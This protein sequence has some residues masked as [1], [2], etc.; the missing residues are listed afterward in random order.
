MSSRS[1]LALVISAWVAQVLAF[2]AFGG[3]GLVKLFTPIPALAAMWPWTGQLA[4]IIVRGLGAIDLA[5]GLGVLLPSLT[6]VKPGLTVVAAV[7][8][9]VLQI[10]AMV[11]HISRGEAAA[12]PVNVVFLALAAYVAW[13]RR[14][15]PIRPR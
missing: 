3:T 9:V 1:A 5:G 2:I 6:R 15:L 10:C 4:P 11:F 7:C 12:L 13:S 14:K 8:C